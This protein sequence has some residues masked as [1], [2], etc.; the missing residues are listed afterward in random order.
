MKSLLVAHDSRFSHFDNTAWDEVNDGVPHCV[1]D[2][3]KE[4]NIFLFAEDFGLP[5]KG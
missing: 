2:C 5:W 1:T 3:S 4:D